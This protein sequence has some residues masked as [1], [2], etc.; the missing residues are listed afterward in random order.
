M[1]VIV[2]NPT[3]ETK[4]E[5]SSSGVLIAVIL[6][7]IFV[8]ALVYFGIPVLRSTTTNIPSLQ[9]PSKIDVNVNK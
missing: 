9:I 8:I 6:I 5:E 3:P 1:A 7:I 2:N 4:P